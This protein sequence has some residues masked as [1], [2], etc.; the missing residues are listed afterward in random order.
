M[1]LL[2]GYLDLFSGYGGFHKAIE[3]AGFRFRETYFSEID[4]H[5]IANYSYNFPKSQYVGAIQSISESTCGK[6][7][8]ITF[9]WPCQDNSI[10]GKRKG[11]QSGTR[12]GLLYE[13]VRLI[14]QYRPR[15]FIA[16]NV[17]GLYSVN[18][19][20]DFRNAI[21]VLAYLNESLPQYDIE[22]QLC[23]TRWVL[24]QNRERIF[25][26]GHLRG[27]GSRQVFPIGED[28][29]IYSQIGIGIEN[30][31]NV[32]PSGNGMNGNVYGSNGISP[33][34]STNKGEG[35]KVLARLNSSQDG[36]VFDQIGIEQCLSGGHGNTPKVA[37]KSA[38]KQGYEEAAEGDSINFSFP[39]STT[40]RGR[41][42]KGVAQT[43]DTACNQGVIQVNPSI[44]SDGKQPYQ[45]NR[46]YDSSGISPALNSQITDQYK[47]VEKRV[48]DVSNSLLLQGFML[49]FK[50]TILYGTED[51]RNAIKALFLLFKEIGE[52]EM[53]EWGVGGINTFQQAKILQS[54]MFCKKPY[55]TKKGECEVDDSTS[56]CE[57]FEDERKVRNVWCRTKFGHTPQGRKLEEQLY[58]QFT[59]FMSLMPQFT[60]QKKKNLRCLWET[61]EGSW[62]LRKALST[63]QKIWKCTYE[64]NQSAR[65][66][67]NIRRLTPIETERLQGL[68]DDW[69]KYG[70]YNGEI[71][72]I[73]DTQRYKL[74]G[75]GVTKHMV[76]AI[77]KRLFDLN[78]SDYDRH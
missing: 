34:L 9:G 77:A 56:P 55:G 72:E 65:Q 15:N 68:P 31:G 5:A 53:V 43:L 22:L 39:N 7:D 71:K 63:F 76:L 60:A 12:S 29:G 64:E 4:K 2:N 26:I 25:I 54:N 32:N 75:N 38:T 11:Q 62:L 49:I 28:F 37:I 46:V 20:V 24:P 47:I 61:T 48:N 1:E 69:T 30:I 18:S 40:R 50:E 70:N 67:S 42:G 66:T 58:K 3:E 36:Q 6:L 14:G 78:Y 8:L 17:K 33:T 45:Q 74:C 23:N 13:A 35:I 73:S 16:E 41:I 19:G 27:T 21:E 52:E 57:E 59:G 10:A 51:K 44:E